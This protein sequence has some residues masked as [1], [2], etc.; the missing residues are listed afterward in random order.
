V[1]ALSPKSRSKIT[2]G[3]FC[4]G[5]GVFWLFQLIVFV[6]GH[7]NPVSHAPVVSL[8]SIPS[9]SDATCVCLPVSCAR[10]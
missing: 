2:R 7:A 10:I 4:V 1:L 9:S 3:L 5:S 6:Y 8:D